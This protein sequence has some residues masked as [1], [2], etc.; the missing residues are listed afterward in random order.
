MYGYSGF[1]CQNIPLYES[2]QSV[3]DNWYAICIWYVPVVP[4]FE[5]LRSLFICFAYIIS[6]PAGSVHQTTSRR[7]KNKEHQM[8]FRSCVVIFEDRACQFVYPGTDGQYCRNMWWSLSA[9]HWW[10]LCSSISLFY[11]YFLYICPANDA[12][13]KRRLRNKKGVTLIISDMELIRFPM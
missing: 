2:L 5:R 1:G 6:F 3:T 12:F 4:S 13:V 11:C 8:A 7:R 9:I 10:T